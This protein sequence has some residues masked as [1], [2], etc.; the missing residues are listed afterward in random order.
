MKTIIAYKIFYNLGAGTLGT[1]LYP[2]W[3]VFEPYDTKCIWLRC[4]DCGPFTCFKTRQDALK[5]PWWGGDAAPIQLWKVRIK[6]SKDKK[7]WIKGYEKRWWHGAS[8]LKEN[9]NVVFADEFECLEM[10]EKIK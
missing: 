8:L 7:V 3:K 6:P 4:D 2:L 10:V 1:R 9:E 5:S